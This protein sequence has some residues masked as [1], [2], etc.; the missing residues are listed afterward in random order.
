MLIH[1][2]IF[3]KKLLLV[4]VVARIVIRLI[5]FPFLLLLERLQNVHIRGA[6]VDQPPLKLPL[7]CGFFRLEL[8]LELSL[9]LLHSQHNLDLLVAIALS[10]T[11]FTHEVFVGFPGGLNQEV[12]RRFCIVLE[13]LE[14][15]LDFT[16]YLLIVFGD[17]FD[18]VGYTSANCQVL[19]FLWFLGLQTSVTSW[20]ER[21][22]VFDDQRLL[23]FERFSAS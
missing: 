3:L 19:I 16:D 13:Q 15:R 11:L 22:I 18:G 6:L 10:A 21:L 5:L 2:G 20:Q 4:I 23:D 8:L 12:G 14:G 17:G 1:I 7:F 9:S